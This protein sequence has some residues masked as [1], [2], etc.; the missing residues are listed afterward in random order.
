MKTCANGTH[1]TYGDLVR[2]Y[3]TLNAMERFEKIRHGL[4]INFV[5]EFPAAEKGSDACSR[6]WRVD[7]QPEA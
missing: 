2:Q 1:P 5:A 4:Y 7:A 6:D 3:V